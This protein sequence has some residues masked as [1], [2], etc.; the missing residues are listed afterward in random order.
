[1][2][3]CN[4]GSPSISYPS[5]H[6]KYTNVSKL[7]VALVN[8]GPSG[9]DGSEVTVVALLAWDEVIGCEVITDDDGGGDEDDADD[10]NDDVGD[11]DA[12]DGDDEEFVVWDV[13]GPIVVE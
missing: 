11:T 5:S 8:I 9:V 12:A 13:S 3:H 2:T 10:G 4:Q 1:M 6:A 7:N